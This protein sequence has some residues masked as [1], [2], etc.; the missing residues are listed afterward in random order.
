MAGNCGAYFVKLFMKAKQVL[1]SLKD[2][3]HSQAIRR[4]CHF[5]SIS[6]RVSRAMVS[7]VKKRDS[8]P[9][10]SG[11]IELDSHADTIVAGANCTILEYIGKVRDISPY[12]DDYD[13]V[14][15]VPIVHAAKVWQS[16]YTGLTYILI[17]QEALWMGG[18][19]KISPINPN[20]FTD[21]GTGRSNFGLSFI[22]YYRR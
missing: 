14:T 8:A 1:P 4:I 10:T 7:A 13:S 15:N 12:R 18:H 6:R 20:Q 11:R 9:I 21:K 3:P 16:P 5:R 2:R 22:N 19:M 17:F